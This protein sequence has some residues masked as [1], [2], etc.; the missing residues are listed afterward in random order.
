MKSRKRQLREWAFR[1]NLIMPPSLRVCCF[2][3][4]IL[5]FFVKVAEG[6]VSKSEIFYVW[7]NQIVR[8]RVNVTILFVKYD[9]INWRNEM[10]EKKKKEWCVKYERYV[11][12]FA[13]LSVGLL[14]RFPWAWS[15]FKFHTGVYP[16]F[17]HTLTYPGRGKSQIWGWEKRNRVKMSERSNVTTLLFRYFWRKIDIHLTFRILSI[18]IS[19]F[20]LFC[21]TSKLTA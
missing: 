16:T 17:L 13:E 3:K 20:Y 6:T 18:H 21:N 15:L 12:S 14:S 8:R 19:T 11:D 5:F 7:R 2:L 9:K 10:K 1:K 4:L